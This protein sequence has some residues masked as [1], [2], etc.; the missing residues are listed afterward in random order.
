MRLK[1]VFLA[2]LYTGAYDGTHVEMASK[3]LIYSTWAINVWTLTPAKRII[4]D[5]ARVTAGL[6]AASG[7][8]GL[9]YR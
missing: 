5:M 9:K 1:D 2:G 6:L 3:S 7:A 4:F 8:G